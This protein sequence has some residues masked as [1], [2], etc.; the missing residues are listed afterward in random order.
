MAWR[1][2]NSGAA[3]WRRLASP[4][5]VQASSSVF[6]VIRQLS[7][8][9]VTHPQAISVQL[10]QQALNEGLSHLKLPNSPPS[11]VHV[12]TLT[13]LV[14][15]SETHQASGLFLAPPPPPFQGL[16]TPYMRTAPDPYAKIMLVWSCNHRHVDSKA[17]PMVEIVR[18]NASLHLYEEHISCTAH[19][20]WAEL[21]LVSYSGRCPRHHTYTQ[22][23]TPLIVRICSQL[24]CYWDIGNSFA[25]PVIVCMHHG[26]DRCGCMPSSY[27]SW[28]F[29]LSWMLC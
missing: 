23:H 25:N 22:L 16:P 8:V 26:V 20:P 14:C 15:L 21:V 6:Q 19:F 29:S 18:T 27:F 1:Q 17:T 12:M 28:S 24:M 2:R 5:S 3:A 7:L 11:A 4:S 9:H 13:S 10:K